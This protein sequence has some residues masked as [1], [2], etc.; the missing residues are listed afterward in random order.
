MRNLQLK[1]RAEVLARPW[2]KAGRPFAPA[3]GLLQEG[4]THVVGRGLGA[5]APGERVYEIGS[6]TKVF[7][8]ALLAD[9]VIQGKARLEETVPALQA[10]GIEP[11]ISLLH[12]V[13]HTSG[14]PR[15]PPN[16]DLSRESRA[17]PYARY[18]SADLERC[19]SEPPTERGHVG[20]YAY[21]N[22]GM[23][24]L[25]E[26]LAARWGL[27]YE[28]AVVTRLCLPLGMTDTRMTLTPDQE[29]RRVRGCSPWGRSVSAWDF[30][31]LSGAGGLRSTGNDLLK[32]LAAH[33]EPA[34][35]PLTR[36]LQLSLQ[37]RHWLARH[38][39]VGLGW[40]LS[41]RKGHVLHWHNGA[42]G[43]FNSFVGLLPE[44]H[45]GVVVLVNR[46]L[47]W[48]AERGLTRDLATSLGV[49]LLRPLVRGE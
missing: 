26:L 34:T 21:S 19:L 8:G 32:F 36:A 29:R 2:L 18:V 30:R 14:L 6:V 12:L 37:P 35:T 48:A 1:E 47:T 13:T 45:V 41:E 4:R 20:R 23:G 9:L 11:P 43:G 31:A 17:N 27:S 5:V 16:L 38:Q 10:P 39:A 49:R 40:H 46:G 33:L 42:T 7:T 25:G 44:Q 22:L 24:L 3:I 15:L 28:E